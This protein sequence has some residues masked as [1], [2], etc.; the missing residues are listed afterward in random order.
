[1]V[2]RG[3]RL[4]NDRGL[5]IEAF[6]T[7]IRWLGIG[8]ELPNWLGGMTFVGSFPTREASLR[9][10]SPREASVRA[11]C[12]QTSEDAGHPK[13]ELGLFSNAN[14]SAEPSYDSF[15]PHRVL[16]K[17]KAD[18]DNRRCPIVTGNFS[19]RTGGQ[20]SAKSSLPDFRGDNQLETVKF[21][22]L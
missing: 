12:P 7:S 9:Q 11:H 13:Q 6:A 16:M 8:T 1:M 15:H 4:G 14:Y 18:N 17:R 2:A 20:C 3:R 10:G 5:A 21:A 19:V 22:E